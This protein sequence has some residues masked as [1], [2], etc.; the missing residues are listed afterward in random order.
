MKIWKILRCGDNSDLAVIFEMTCSSRTRGHAL[1]LSV[2]IC[3]TDV[4]RRFLG[5]RRVLLWNALLAEIIECDSLT[6]TH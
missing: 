3:R 4:L 1:K 6:A 5:A 2:P